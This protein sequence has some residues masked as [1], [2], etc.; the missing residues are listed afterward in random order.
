MLSRDSDLRPGVSIVRR[1]WAALSLVALVAALGLAAGCVESSEEDAQTPATAPTVA[2]SAVQTDSEGNFVTAPPSGAGEAPDVESPE[3][4]GEEVFASVCTT[5]HLNNG[6][7]AGGVGPQLAGLG[8]DAAS[9]TTTVTNGRGA[10]PAGLVSGAD[11]ENVV[12]YV[13]SIQ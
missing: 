11:L 1:L 13:V 8:R 10:M 6:Q 9:V 12:A 4:A 7:D 2:N 5:C 3:V